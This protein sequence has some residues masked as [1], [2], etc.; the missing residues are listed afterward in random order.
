MKQLAK[1]FLSTATLLTLSACSSNDELL[2][3]ELSTTAAESSTSE[4]ATS[5]ELLESSSSETATSESTE[6]VEQTS[7]SESGF[8]WYSDN[9]LYA[10][11]EAVKK[12]VE[13]QMN[14]IG[15]DD[16]V[17][18]L[19]VN[20]IQTYL[21]DS[22]IVSMDSEL[23]TTDIDKNLV[24]SRSSLYID[25]NYNGSEPSEDMSKFI[26]DEILATSGHKYTIE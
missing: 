21:Y 23:S 13:M 24:Y 10:T 25:I 22:G 9:S 19:V 7:S 17:K 4:T 6:A 18:A 8:V 11:N 20:A 15:T 16:P 3:A 1:L 12:T 14:E 2:G 26:S 5:D